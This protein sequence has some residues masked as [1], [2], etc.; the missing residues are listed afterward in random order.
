MLF[1]F[2]LFFLIP[3]FFVPPSLR[4]VLIVTLERGAVAASTHA[5]ACSGIGKYPWYSLQFASDPSLGAAPACVA[6]LEI[7]CDVIGCKCAAPAAALR[8][9]QQQQ[10]P[11]RQP[12]SCRSHVRPRHRGSVSTQF[13]SPS[14]SPLIPSMHHVD[15]CAPAKLVV[16]VCLCC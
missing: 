9:P 13:G 16:C 1:C 8:W 11:M 12:P 7:I 3:S 15:A 5:A 2:P 14:K 6:S 10:Q 4:P